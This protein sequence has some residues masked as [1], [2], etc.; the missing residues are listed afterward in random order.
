MTAIAQL[1]AHIRGMLAARCAKD[2]DALMI[3]QIEGFIRQ[4]GYGVRGGGVRLPHRNS[5][6]GVVED[7]G[8]V[9]HGLSI[10][11]D[12]ESHEHDSE[13]EEAPTT[14]AFSRT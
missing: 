2:T 9:H 12:S 7:S 3:E 11:W 13:G 8:G 5:C 1:E 4:H 10:T 14:P 6:V